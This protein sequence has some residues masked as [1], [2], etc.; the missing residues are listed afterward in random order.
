M[1][2]A[3]A[4]RLAEMLETENK[5]DVHLF[6]I[7]SFN[8]Q[9]PFDPSKSADKCLLSRI[10][11]S[12]TMT[13]GG[14]HAM[15]MTPMIEFSAFKKIDSSFD[16]GKDWLL[17]NKVILLV[18]ELSAVPHTAEEYATMSGELDRLVGRAGS[19]LLYSSHNRIVED[20]SLSRRTHRWMS[21]PRFQSQS[22]YSY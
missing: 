20:S 21:I 10:A 16:A 2:A 1:L 22:C 4:K 11:H 19:A 18:G 7:I 17:T 12:M 8:D 14:D 3:V 6:H 9:S 15:N 13:T 5:N